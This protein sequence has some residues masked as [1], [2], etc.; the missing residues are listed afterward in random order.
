MKNVVY[1]QHWCVNFHWK[2]LETCVQ[3]SHFSCWSRWGEFTRR[4]NPPEMA[5]GIAPGMVVLARFP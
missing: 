3:W 1:A 5:A 2:T 4:E